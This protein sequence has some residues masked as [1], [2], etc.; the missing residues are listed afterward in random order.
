MSAEEV[1]NWIGKYFLFTLAAVGGYIYLFSETPLL[2]LGRSE[3]LA[4]GETIIPV[5][6]GQLAIV[7]RWFFAAERPTLPDMTKV[8]SWL[9]KGPPAIV[10]IL[11]S[12]SVLSMVFADQQQANWS[13][14]PDQ[15]R[16]VIVFAVSLLNVTTL[17]VVMRYF[18]GET[19]KSDHSN[20]KNDQ[21][22]AGGD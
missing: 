17:I 20:D 14:D 12:A 10:I 22:D 1:R 2:P 5:F 19:P 21:N 7:Y 6:L 15:F 11:V 3:S 16:R 4:A 13:P 18:P 8:P 9:I